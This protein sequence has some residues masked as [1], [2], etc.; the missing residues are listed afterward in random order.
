[1]IARQNAEAVMRISAEYAYDASDAFQRLT[2]YG[3]AIPVDFGFVCLWTVF[4]LAMTAL[5]FAFGFSV[6][7]GQALALAG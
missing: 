4:G 5:A 2:R 1:V 3:A 7:V 6:D